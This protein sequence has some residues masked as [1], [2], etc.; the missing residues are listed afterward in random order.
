MQ[1]NIG[2]LIVHP[3]EEFA[4]DS[5]V[6]AMIL[7][8]IDRARFAAHVACPARTTGNAR[9]AVDVFS[10][11]NAVGIYTMSFAPTIRYRS[12]LNTL[13]GT[14]RAA[15][16]ILSGFGGLIRYIRRNNI[17][18]L[19][20]NE[21]PRDTTYS[22][23]LARATGARVVT[24]VYALP[25]DWM[26]PLT[27]RNMH[28]ADALVCVSNAV[29]RGLLE[30]GYPADKIVTVHNGVEL[31]RWNPDT[32]GSALRAEYGIPSDVPVIGIIARIY[33]GKGFVELLR[34]LASIRHEVPD[35]R[36]LIVGEDDRAATPGMASHTAELKAL[37][38]SL[39]ISDRVVFTGFRSD[40][41][42]VLAATDI[43]AMP[44][45]SEAFALAYL[46]ALAMRVPVVA[47]NSSGTPE[48]VEHGIC[49]LLSDP[50]DVPALA[51]NLRRLINAPELRAQM[52]ANGRR[53][54]E[55]YFSAAHFGQQM[56]QVYSELLNGHFVGSFKHVRASTHPSLD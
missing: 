56:G 43:Y 45:P 12:R 35:F 17:R 31:S 37:A 33:P 10:Q 20:T 6:D 49:G 4:S 26:Q 18:V 51:A 47:L 7:R 28:H 27:R 1:Q 30:M 29:G 50:G 25:G 48:L 40:I 16:A 8:Y 5:N 44:S 32:D 23:L 11:I 24:H 34:A 19:H 36:M 14:A 42:H 54:V 9:S 22:L 52:G 55:T 3:T 41:A 13:L 53:R 21:S 15:P 2:V 38:A 46:E 39:A